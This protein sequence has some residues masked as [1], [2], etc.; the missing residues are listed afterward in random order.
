MKY[1]SVP[2][3]LNSVNDE[4]QSTALATIQQSGYLLSHFFN[5]EVLDLVFIFNNCQFY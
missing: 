2:L 1:K 5:R 4:V 3:S